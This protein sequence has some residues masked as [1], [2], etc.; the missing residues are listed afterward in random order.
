M[1][2]AG[3]FRDVQE[4]AQIGQIETERCLHAALPAFGCT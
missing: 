3:G 2:D 1:R 4:E